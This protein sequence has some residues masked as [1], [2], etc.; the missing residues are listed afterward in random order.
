MVRIRVRT[1]VR[2]RLLFCCSLLDH[3]KIGVN[4]NIDIHININIK[5]IVENR[6][7]DNYNT[8]GFVSVR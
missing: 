6:V 2:Y 7:A 4:N 8:F 1:R 5:I 3:F